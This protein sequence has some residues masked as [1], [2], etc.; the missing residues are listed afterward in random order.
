MGDVGEILVLSRFSWLIFTAMVT[1]PP[2][3]SSSPCHDNMDMS[4]LPHKPAFST[5]R[6]PMSPTENVSMNMCSSPPTAAPTPELPRID[7]PRRAG[8]LPEY[9]NDSSGG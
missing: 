2:I 5:A 1:T 3:P 8:G 6:A 9:V 4:P 7:L